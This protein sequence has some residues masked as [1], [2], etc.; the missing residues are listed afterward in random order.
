VYREEH[1]F[2]LHLQLASH[3]SASSVAH[4]CAGHCGSISGLELDRR[5]DV[6]LSASYDKTVR[7]WNMKGKH[8]GCLA[9]HEAPVLEL[10]ANNNGR[11][12]S[13]DRSGNVKLWDMDSERSTWTLKRV[14]KGHITSMAW[15]DASGGNSAWTGCFATGGQDGR[16]RLWDPRSNQNPAKI[17]LHVD[18]GTCGA[19]TGIILGTNRPK[20]PAGV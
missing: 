11:V 7:I 4:N 8:R 20:T 6:A 17:P 10:R 1:V 2:A 18:A 19:V 15:A 14:H 12:I 13:G 3:V 9:E 5:F 16:L